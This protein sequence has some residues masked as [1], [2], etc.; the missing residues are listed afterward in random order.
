MSIQAEGW[1]ETAEE[2]DDEFLG[3]AEIWYGDLVLFA[4][5]MGGW[6]IP[7]NQHVSIPTNIPY[8]VEANRAKP[9]SWSTWW[10]SP[11]CVS[12][13]ALYCRHSLLYVASS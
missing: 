3:D 12:R 9:H 13:G 2:L 7:R 1:E 5:F 8:K 6:I 11:I 4:C 10:S